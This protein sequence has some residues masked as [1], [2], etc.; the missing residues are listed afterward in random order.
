MPEGLISLLKFPYDLHNA[1][2]HKH[3]EITAQNF[4]EVDGREFVGFLCSVY[5]SLK[6]ETI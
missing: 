4:P 6:P 3:L 1:V 2:V 5:S